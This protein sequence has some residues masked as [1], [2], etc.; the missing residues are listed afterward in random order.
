M[1]RA[2]TLIELLVVLAIIAILITCLLDNGTLPALL[3]GWALYPIRILR[4]HE[5]DWPS[6]IVG[7]VCVVGLTFGVHYF[8]RW[9]ASQRPT[10]AREGGY[11]S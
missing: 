2:F 1:R 7:T 9:F 8:G 11:A 4:E 6:T 10:P 3:F 5:I